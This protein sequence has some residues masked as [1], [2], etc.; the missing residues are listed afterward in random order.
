MKIVVYSQGKKGAIMNA[1]KI[2]E[3]AFFGIA[4]CLY[5]IGS[6]ELALHIAFGDILLC[7]LP[8]N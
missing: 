3:W 1:W 4:L 7:L 5:I 2:I 6:H 8:K